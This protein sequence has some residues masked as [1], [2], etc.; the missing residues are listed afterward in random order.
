MGMLNY[1]N[2]K[3]NITSGIKFSLPVSLLI[4][5]FAMFSWGKLLFT[6]MKIFRATCG[7]AR[8]YSTG[9]RPL[10]LIILTEDMSGFAESYITSGELS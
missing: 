2:I 9:I 1:V 6:E 4:K 5:I 8:G 10:T 7:T 3:L